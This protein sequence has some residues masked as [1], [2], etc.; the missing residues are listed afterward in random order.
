MH[1]TYTHSEGGWRYHP[2]LGL[3]A[4]ELQ[5][6]PRHIWRGQV[7]QGLEELEP[8][9]RAQD[10]GIQQLADRARVR[11]LAGARADV[12]PPQGPEDGHQQVAQRGPAQRANR[13]VRG[14]GTAV[15]DTRPP[16]LRREEQTLAV[17]VDHFR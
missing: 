14:A 13:G 11:H 9:A 3:G 12:P 5:A 1:K 6:D 17:Q 8:L 16:L 4:A 7:R 15:Q 10:A 2:L